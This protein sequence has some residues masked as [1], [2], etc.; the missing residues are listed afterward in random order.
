MNMIQRGA[1]T[2]NIVETNALSEYLA[3]V[4]PGNPGSTAYVWN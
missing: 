1:K 4:V 3:G 2:P